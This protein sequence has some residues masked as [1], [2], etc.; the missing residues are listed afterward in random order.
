MRLIYL[1]LLGF[2]LTGCEY[3]WT[4]EEQGSMIKRCSDNGLSYK[5]GDFGKVFCVSGK[6]ES[7]CPGVQENPT[8][9]GGRNV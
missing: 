8:F 5:I 3:Q 1:V 9:S 4:P 7:S 2:V 6:V